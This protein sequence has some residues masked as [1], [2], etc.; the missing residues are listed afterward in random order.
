MLLTFPKLMV[1]NAHHESFSTW[2][3]FSPAGPELSPS[4][5]LI[6][7]LPDAIR[8]RRP[9]NSGLSIP[10]AGADSSWWRSFAWEGFF[11]AVEQCKPERHTRYISPRL[12]AQRNNVSLARSNVRTG[13]IPPR[14]NNLSSAEML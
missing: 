3:G 6:C 10:R 13:G 7:A 8:P 5:Q 14:Q 9:M 2:N 1:N 12:R 4:I 11:Q